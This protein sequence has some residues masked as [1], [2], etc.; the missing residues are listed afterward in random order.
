VEI[1][2]RSGTIDGG[3]STRIHKK[4]F[5]YKIEGEGKTKEGKAKEKSGKINF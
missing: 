4:S 1:P 5:K 3:R 2:F